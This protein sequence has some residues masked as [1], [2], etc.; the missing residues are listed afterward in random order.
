MGNPTLPLETS[1]AAL[2]VAL[3]AICSLSRERL[4]EALLHFHGSLRLDFTED[5]LSHLSDE[6]LRH[7]LLAAYIHGRPYRP[8]EA[9]RPSQD[10]PR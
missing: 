9:G 5:F 2:D 6:K 8:I 4:M 1:P 7:L 10:S 3:T